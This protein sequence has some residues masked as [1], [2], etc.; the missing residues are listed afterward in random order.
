MPL[1]RDNVVN[2]STRLTISNYHIPIIIIIIIKINI[3]RRKSLVSTDTVTKTFNKNLTKN[4]IHVMS[5]KCKYFQQNIPKI[6]PSS[7]SK[8]H[9]VVNIEI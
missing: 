4:K 3:L 1:A 5:Y 8:M 7:L 2:N 9:E 6:Y